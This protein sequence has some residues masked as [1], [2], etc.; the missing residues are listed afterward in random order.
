MKTIET[1]DLK[2]SDFPKMP[3]RRLARA[4]AEGLEL[5][6]YT[7]V[8]PYS[9]EW[10]RLDSPIKAVRWIHHL[11]GKPWLSP[12]MLKDVVEVLMQHFKWTCGTR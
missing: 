7:G 2:L 8:N 4:T 3:K 10:A 12:Q 11:A 1:I 6:A 5:L 9:I